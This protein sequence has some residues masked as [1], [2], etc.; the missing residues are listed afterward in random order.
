[1]K[2]FLGYA[3]NNTINFEHFTFQNYVLAIHQ[4]HI[5]FLW[6]GTYDGLWRYDG[7]TF[8]PFRN[9]LTNKNSLSNN[10]VNAVT[11]D[12]DNNLW[13]GTEDGL[14]QFDQRTITFHHYYLHNDTTS[15]IERNAIKDI[16]LSQTGGYIWVGT[17]NEGL[18]KFDIKTKKFSLVFNDKLKSSDESNRI[19][20]FCHFTENKELVGTNN[21]IYVID[22]KNNS[23]DKLSDKLDGLI[24]ND[25][26]LYPNN[27]LWLATAEGLYVYNL[28]YEQII[29]KLTTNSTPSIADN[30]IRKVMKDK[31]GNIW[32]GT[33]EGGVNK[34]NFDYKRSKI[35]TSQH[36][37]KEPLNPASLSTNVINT[38]FEDNNSNIWIGGERGSLN[39]YSPLSRKFTLYRNIPNDKNS[40]IDNSVRT[41]LEDSEGILWVGTDCG[42]NK[43]NRKSN[44]YQ[45]FNK[46]SYNSV[47]N[48][49]IKCIMESSNGDIWI[50]TDNGLNKYDKRT[51]RF[52]YHLPK[53]E[54]PLT[55]GNNYILCLYEDA[56]E[57][58]WYGSW[59]G[60]LTR[61][62]PSTGQF[63][64]YKN[65][66]HDPTSISDNIVTSICYDKTGNLWIGTS[67]GLNLIDIK[68]GKF[69]SFKHSPAENG[70]IANDFIW[71]VFEDSKDRLLIL[72]KNG[73]D[74]FDRQ[75]FTFHK[76]IDNRSNMGIAYG[77]LEDAQ[78]NIWFSGT[79][80]II[81][82]INSPDSI[83]KFKRYSTKDG[84][85]SNEFAMGAYFKSKSGE[86]FFG[87]TQGLNSFYPEKIFDDNTI[88]Q[89]VFSEF[90]IFN[91][92]VRPDSKS[93]LTS[94][95]NFAEKLKLSY[96]ENVFSFQFAALH[97]SSP[98]ENVYAYKMEG[99]D[100]DWITTDASRRYVTYT[101]LPAG[102]Y[103]FKVKAA[104]SDD[105][106][107]QVPK[108]LQIIISPPY[109]KTTL[110]RIVFVVLFFIAFT[111]LANY[112]SLELIR[113][114]QALERMVHERTLK[115]EETNT[116]LAENQTKVVR[117][118]QLLERQTIELSE[119]KDRIEDMARKV[120]ESDLSKLNF[121]TNISH[122]FRTPLTL[123]SG[124]IKKLITSDKDM[125]FLD[126]FEIYKMIERNANRLLSLI[127]QLMDF[128]KIETGQLKLHVTQN[129]INNNIKTVLEPFELVAKQKDISFIHNLNDEIEGWIDLDKFEKILSNLLSNAFKFTPK[130]G[131]VEVNL[132][133]INIEH[134]DRIEISIKDNGI[135]IPENEVNSIFNAFYQVDNPISRSTGTG[136]GLALTAELV[137]LHKGE[138]SVK[139]ILNEGSTFIFNL[140]IGKDFYSVEEISTDTQPLLIELK[141]QDLYNENSLDNLNN[142]N[143]NNDV[144]DG[145]P[146][147]LIVDDNADIRTYL[148]SELAND[149]TIIEAADGRSG[150]ESATENIPDLII[151][152]IMMPI[153]DGNEMSR[154]IKTDERTCHIP[155]LLLTAR[156]AEEKQVEGLETGADDY[157]T[158]PFN[159]KILILKIHNVLETQKSLREK[160]WGN[161]L[162]VKP[163]KTKTANSTE[164]KFVQK[165]FEFIDINLDNDDLDILEVAREMNMSR[166]QLFRKI[167]A[168]T[169]QTV[170]EFIFCY[171]LQKA[172]NLLTE[173]EKSISE[174]CFA[175]G[176]K[177][178]SHFS[179]RFKKHFGLTPS[180]YINNQQEN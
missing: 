145:K 27:L 156:T 140:P 147:I 66:A 57:N 133:K 134:T 64:I 113:K 28:D 59:D 124:P 25:I 132:A 13:L 135:G 166:A 114:K 29:F 125:S 1:M 60:G 73:V 63:K 168:L 128:R 143:K 162:P 7:Y 118:N 109:Y 94:D 11:S 157:I 49:I 161:T 15:N 154:L 96:K 152:D 53:P 104:N 87:G 178:P 117:Q 176:F 37:H 17:R 89:I 91:K 142:E 115:L 24:V 81:K 83:P 146:K 55:Y 48:D 179:T 54:Y 82:Y 155:I 100:K 120:H 41:I 126:R 172:A 22:E 79:N 4:D 151:S 144:I 5:G 14:N 139:S 30:D 116:E 111:L 78:Q 90:S 50:G 158:K 105:I 32:V 45:A 44:T 65:V 23:L 42:L 141:T 138:I 108:E 177:N 136:I 160:F 76:L 18:Y 106:W 101:N 110:F 12:K 80:G 19:N 75:T 107:N 69:R 39:K 16:S 77:M 33:N 170:S 26:L 70:S 149:Y 31:D 148:K 112:R 71:Q 164:Q 174:V 62:D 171:R 38:I 123:I 165:L 99:F 92:P 122:E 8:L 93:I 40:L 35:L 121:F 9:D 127:N 95:I 56:N 67:K 34:L 137:K 84:L 52:S 173:G 61:Y 88:P 102:D 68:T 2:C 150:Y 36:F 153:M 163:F 97:Y 129:S 20:S 119:Q 46:N 130:N 169:N 74:I 3:Q 6:F 43:I 58:I 72:N 159:V 86:M 98:E 175:V 167:K 47:N 85:Q 10:W 51:S 180:E 103:I 131:M 21:G